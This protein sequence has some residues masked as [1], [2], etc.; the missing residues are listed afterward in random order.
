MMGYVLTYEYQR[1]P[2]H[3]KNYVDLSGAYPSTISFTLPE[4]TEYKTEL[5]DFQ[6]INEQIQV[7]ILVR[8]EI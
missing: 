6:N 2:A 3:S 4:G 8:P 7:T 5:L 1:V